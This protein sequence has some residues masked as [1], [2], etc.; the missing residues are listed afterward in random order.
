M[1]INTKREV[2]SAAFQIT[3]VE[4]K[5]TKRNPQPP[6][7][8]STLQQEAARKLGFSTSQTMRVAQRLYEGIEIDS[9]TIGLITYMRTDSITLSQD[10]IS[11]S[12]SLIDTD[13]GE[14]YLPEKPRV[15]HTKAKNAQEGQRWPKLK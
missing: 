6:F 2:E 4:K 8:T 14:E 9:E 3:K 13:Y 1:A 11:G 10:A 12:R 15:F 7:T 5:R